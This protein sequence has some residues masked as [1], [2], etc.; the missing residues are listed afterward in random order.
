MSKWMGQGFLMQELSRLRREA[1]VWTELRGTRGGR[2]GSG[3]RIRGGGSRRASGDPDARDCRAE[4]GVGGGGDSNPRRNESQPGRSPMS[5]VRS[6]NEMGPRVRSRVE[7]GQLRAETRPLAI[8]PADEIFGPT[9]GRH[10]ESG[11]INQCTVT[12]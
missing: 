3:E 2:A 5:G 6:A 4:A 12:R 8:A 7:T 9:K 11:C 10:P 1:V